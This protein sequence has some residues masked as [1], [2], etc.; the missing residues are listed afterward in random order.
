MRAPGS[1]LAV[2]FGFAVTAA[3]APP[4]TSLIPWTATPDPAKGPP[5]RGR[6]DRRTVAGP[7]ARRLPPRRHAAGHR[8]LA[9]REGT[10]RPVRDD[11]DGPFAGHL[12]CRHGDSGGELP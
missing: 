3:G 7:T 5:P 10:R 4:Q 2:V 8:L 9:R 1:I 12:G 11:A 6:E